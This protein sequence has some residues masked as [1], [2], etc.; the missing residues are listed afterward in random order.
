LFEP[1]NNELVV[2]YAEDSRSRTRYIGTR[3][4]VGD[5]AT[6]RAQAINNL[7]RILPKIEMRRYDDA[8]AIISAGGDYEPSLLLFDDIWSDGQIK[9]DGDT[10]VAIPARD[11]LL[12][13]GSKGRAG[14]K[15]L[16][17]MVEKLAR[18]PHRLTDALFVYRD[19]RFVR[20]GKH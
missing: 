12:V 18:G 4:D 13:T 11:V 6:L 5:R 10:V 16:R 17:G 7:K 15:A 1:F 3:E 2:V 9:F 14:L 8:L 19:N 20:F